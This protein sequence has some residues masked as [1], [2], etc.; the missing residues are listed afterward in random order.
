[1]NKELTFR[2]GLR[3]TLPTIFGYLGIGIAFGMIG[4]A[5]GLNLW[6]IFL[7][8]CLVYAGSAQFIM[9]GLMAVQSP[10]LSIILAVFLVN[11]RMILMSMT[12][13]RYFKNEKMWKNIWL[14]TLL[15]DE[16]FALGM[17]K[18]NYTDGILSFPWFNAVNL[19][20]YASWA[21]ATLIGAIL[22][23]F[24]PNPSQF[25]LEFA[26]IAMFIGLLYL[27]VINDRTKKLSL[28]LIVIGLVFLLFYVGLIFIPANLLILLVTLVCCGLGM[29][30]KH[31]FF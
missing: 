16:S 18:Q 29:V 6:L 10:I 7:L 15:T 12:T 30:V 22:G 19:F 31:V 14:G 17:N 9:V 2:Q 3:E 27:Q 24:I 20:S 26:V 21:F 28:Q 8:S 13:A 4:R 25:G 5:S 11:S 23:S 1:M